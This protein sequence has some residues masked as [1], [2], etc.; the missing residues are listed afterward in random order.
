MKSLFVIAFLFLSVVCTVA[1]E[2]FVIGTSG[3]VFSSPNGTLE[4]TIGEISTETY[5]KNFG[6]LTQGFHQTFSE[7]SSTTNGITVYPIPARDFLFIKIPVT[8]TYQIEIFNLH[9]VRMRNGQVSSDPVN[10]IH[11]VDIIN[12]AAAL[13]QLRVRNI[14]SGKSS[15]FKIILL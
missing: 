13:Y 15:A 9:G 3:G 6:F 12:L 10:N 4:W 2:H 1:Q 7:E 14:A 5:Q 8:G 11:Q